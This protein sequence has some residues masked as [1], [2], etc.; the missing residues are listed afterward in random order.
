MAILATGDELTM[1]GCLLFAE[2]PEQ[3]LPNAHIRVSRFRGTERGTGARQNLVEDVRVEG[4]IPHAV[5]AARR[6]IAAVQPRRRA[7][8]R[9]GVFEDVALVPEDVWLE[10]V[11]NAAGARALPKAGLRL[12]A[13]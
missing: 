3:V 12:W 4:P 9:G 5:P 6:R 11:V 2:H 7:L 13:P 10:G 1:A 8:G